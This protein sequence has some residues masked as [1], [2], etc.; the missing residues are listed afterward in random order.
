[1]V[2]WRTTG[3][4]YRRNASFG[5]VVVVGGGGGWQAFQ[6]SFWTDT[7]ERVIRAKTIQSQRLISV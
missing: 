1:M 6:L 3:D 5:V 4:G 2:A 7:K